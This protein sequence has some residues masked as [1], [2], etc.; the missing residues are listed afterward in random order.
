MGVGPLAGGSALARAGHGALTRLRALT[1]GQVWILLAGLVATHH[2]LLLHTTQDQL[3][4]VVYA[5][6]LWGGALIC[7]EDLL[8]SLRPSPTRWG[9]LVGAALLVLLLVRSSRISHYDVFVY[10][11]PPLEGVALVLLCAAPGRWRPY[12]ASLVIL[13]LMV[14][15]RILF[16][17]VP[18][19]VFNRFT[20]GSTALLMHAIGLHPMVSDNIVALSEGGGVRIG[21]TCNGQAMILQVIAAAVIFLLAFPLS[22]WRDRLLVLCAAPVVSVFG[23]AVRIFLLAWIIGQS[24]LPHRKALFDFFHKEGGSLVFS[25]IGMCLL[26][27]VHYGLLERD[28]NRLS[29]SSDADA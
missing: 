4:L 26:A 10:L 15:P 1:P 5:L 19:P 23:N 24:E 21:D 8:P 9:V 22:R 16:W 6:L 27:L 2:L 20:A 13:C 28:L 17:S 3:E 7:I 29:D 11:M 14:L 12:A 18:E 25:L